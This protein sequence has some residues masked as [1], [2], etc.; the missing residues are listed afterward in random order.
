M[1]DQT[2]VRKIE[3][4]APAKNLPCGIAAINH[5]ADA[6]Y[7]GGPGFSARA[8]AANSVE[9][10]AQLVRH[11]H[12]FGA[13]VYVAFN[14]IFND[15]ELTRA[16]ALSHTLY[17][18]GAD[19]LIIQDTGLLKSDLPPIALHSSTQMNNRTPERVRFWQDVGFDQVVLARELSL[20]QIREI[21][22]T[23]SV[24]LEFFVHG[25]LCVSYS[26]QCYISEV[27]AGRS[28]NRGECAQ[29]CRHKF[30]LKDSKGRV[31][32]KDSYLLSLKDLNLSGHI[33]ALI[34]AG[35]SSLKI[36]GRLKD[37]H[38]V[39]NVTAHYRRIL[40]GV[41]AG[42][43]DL[44]PA[45]SGVCQFDFTPDP[46]KSFNRG[47]SEYFI[48]AKRNV[49]GDPRSPKS[50]G[51]LLGRITRIDKSFFVVDGAEKI[52]NG[53]G[54]CFFDGRGALVGLRVNRVDGTH[55]FP[56]DDVQR[57]GLR[58]G[59]EMFRNA[60][61]AFA[62][63]LDRSEQCRTIGVNVRLREKE[64]GLELTVTDSD[65]I[66]SVT[67]LSVTA[68][69]A[70]NPEAVKNGAIKQ[71][72]KSGGTVFTVEDVQVDID[73]A[74]FYPAAIF[75][76]IRRNG[77]A[78]HA[79]E[80]VSYFQVKPTQP[81]RDTGVWPLDTISYLDNVRNSKALEFYAE[82]GVTKTDQGLVKA[83]DV[84]D[85]ALMTTKYCIKAQLGRCPKVKGSRKDMSDPLF[86]ADNRG[87]YALE[88]D[89]KKCEMLLRL[90]KE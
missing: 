3:L 82:H 22:A 42:R 76:E 84:Q 38:Y 61:T 18:A 9:D 12:M 83:E 88:F 16:V 35:I 56:K 21:G 7:I 75:N 20:E 14:T 72:K 80:R 60:D 10:I 4:L 59:M 29:F 5:G 36:E 23:S 19:A 77:F 53:D 32:E 6:V 49:V 70:K 43:S 89:C 55:L 87:E 50:K 28:A 26:G 74:S 13:K 47:S 17:D 33:E 44:A 73:G 27:M 52:V 40:D 41:L 34:D 37:E 1:V 54:L 68:E 2:E 78:R 69:E 46:E 63:L 71:L 81:R 62:K 45:S 58:V 86:L 65:G 66:T 48:R 30:D 8:A 64:G 39:K 79:E 24:P 85:A 15:E 31:L 67:E 57:L 11:A 51:K 25:A 90:K